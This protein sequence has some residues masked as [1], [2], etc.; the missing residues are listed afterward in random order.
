MSVAGLNKGLG[1]SASHSHCDMAFAAS[2]WASHH[3]S[4]LC[5]RVVMS[6]Q[7][8]RESSTEEKQ[9]E[10]ELFPCGML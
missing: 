5:H 7:W 1:N 10:N 9:G 6:I 8:L 3:Y 2:L 4:C